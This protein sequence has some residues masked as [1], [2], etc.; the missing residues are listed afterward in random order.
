MLGEIGRLEGHTRMVRLTGQR[1][2]LSIIVDR[3]VE[4]VRPGLGHHVHEPAGGTAELGVGAGGRDHDFLHRIEIERERRALAAALLTEERIVEVGA[5]H[6]NVV[7]DALLPADRQLVAVRT[8]HDRHVGCE[9]RQVQIVAPVVGEA[10]DRRVRQTGGVLHLG[11][12]HDRLRRLDD[13]RLQLHRRERQVQVHSLTDAQAD[14]AAP[15]LAEADGPGADIVRP[16][17][18]EGR[19]ENAALAGGHLALEAGL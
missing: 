7:V 5:V 14:A 4:G 8:L 18:H 10:R 13:H 12:V 11:R 6:R 19:D 16:E 1:A 15:R 3:A 9:Q 17:G 2:V